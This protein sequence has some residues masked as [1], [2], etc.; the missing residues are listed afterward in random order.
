[1]S[2]PD[3]RECRWPLGANPSWCDECQRSQGND[4]ATVAVSPSVAT[5]AGD[6]SLADLLD[7]TERFIRRFVIF[8]NRH[9]LVAV[10]LWVAHVY[11]IRAAIAAAYLRVK[12]AAEESGK[13]TLLE[14]LELLLGNLAINAVSIT[15]AAV[16]RVRDKI[17]PVA[18]L[19]DEID[20]TLRARND[21][22]ARD[23]LALVNA[24][25]R[26]SATVYRTVGKEHDAKAFKAFGPAAVAGIGHLHP[27]TESRCIPI[28][29]DRKTRG[30]GER[31]LRHLVEEAGWSLAERLEAWVT[32]ETIDRLRAASPELPEGLRDRHVEVWWSLWAIAD[33]AGGEWPKLARAAALALHLDADQ[34]DTMTT[35]V[36]LLTHIEAAFEDDDRLPTRD[37][38]S[39]LV[40][41]EEGPWGKWWG[42]EVEHS[43]TPRAAAADLAR[44]L[45]AFGI[46]P[47]V[48][49]LSDGTTA[50]GYAREDFEASWSRYTPHVTDVTHV[51]P[52]ASTV[53]S[54]T[55]VT[56]ESGQDD[57]DRAETL[58]RE[59]FPGTVVL[60][61][62]TW[63]DQAQEL[64]EAGATEW[65][66]ARALSEQGARLT[67]G[68]RIT[69]PDVRLAL[70]REL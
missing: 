52:L 55:S 31:W 17:G 46:K 19:L 26:R 29:L 64:L 24:G 9:Q 30:E 66:A 21:D 58:I 41:N 15:P 63:T 68:H 25:Y 48:I 16:F 14:V 67:N 22:G 39:R 12:S 1:M 56:G 61:E 43:E 70:G 62:E 59:A 8:T 6:S 50:R 23:L 47:K 5:V 57:L 44:H 4:A 20:N 18:L 10:V 7:A 49:K 51:T 2:S 69:A 27:T 36:L 3:C 53:T 38:L 35:G 60:E 34:A 13:T 11:A 42:S 65:E 33:E 54:V 32:D 40:E 37:L 45:R 28:V